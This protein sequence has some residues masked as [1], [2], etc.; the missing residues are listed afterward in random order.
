MMKMS[1]SGLRKNMSENIAKEYF[2]EMLDE[3]EALFS[4]DSLMEEHDSY[5]YSLTAPQK[6]EDKPYKEDVSSCH[7]CE[8]C[9]S[10]RVYAEP[11]LNKGAK[12]FFILPSPEG[13]TLFSPES[14]LYF[15]KW[16]SAMNAERKEIA[17][18]SLI[19]CPVKAFSREIASLCKD[20]L[21]E[22]MLSI[23]PKALV[24]LGE[25]VAQYMLRKSVPFDELRG[26]TYTI[27]GITTFCTYS[28]LDL[29][30]NRGL[31]APIWEDLKFIMS[32]I[33]DE[34]A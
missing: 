20:H 29:T 19:K 24:L 27:N 14:S 3:A 15:S 23:K 9:F 26:K 22:E 32:Y 13:D 31:R 33:G 10:R 4:N 7:K 1:I 8:A 16:L 30:N 6:I 21:K 18:S 25:S 17:V 28:P 5:L 11:I 12:L 34:K 2:L